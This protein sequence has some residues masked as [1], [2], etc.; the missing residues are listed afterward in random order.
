MIAI[1]FGAKPIANPNREW[2][3]GLVLELG[4]VGG[5]PFCYDGVRW[6]QSADATLLV[7]EVMSRFHELVMDRFAQGY[8]ILHGRDY[9]T[10]FEKI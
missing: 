4:M 10:V 6:D 1:S 2:G 3:S 7:S 5:E 9:W 8:F